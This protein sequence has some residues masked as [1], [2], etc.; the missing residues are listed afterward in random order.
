MKTRRVGDATIGRVVEL[1]LPDFERLGFFPDTT[2]EDW[3]PH[4]EWLKERAMDPVSSNLYFAMQSYIVRTAHHTIL[5]DSCVG[6][7]KDRPHRPNWHMKSDSTYLDGLAAA[8]LALEDI[9]YVMCTHLHLDHVGWNTRLL[10]GRWVPTFPNAKYVFSKK[11]YDYWLDT[12]EGEPLASA[13]ADSV[14]P[15]VEAG[16]GVLVNN[17]HALDDEVWLEPTPGHTPDHLAIRLSSG[18]GNAVFSGDL[19]HSPIQCRYPEWRARPDFDPQQ[20]RETR[21]SFL[22]NYCETDTLVC[23]A[24]FPL[25]SAGY[26]ERHGDAFD[27]RYDEADW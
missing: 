23:T 1:N 15:V 27:F 20:A 19:M 4:M 12:Y 14:L 17:D 3:A 9:D 18:G 13:F 26:I 16:R 24:H 6:N 7:D 21:R 25:P 2:E 11:E 5:I 10:D 8:G 22:E